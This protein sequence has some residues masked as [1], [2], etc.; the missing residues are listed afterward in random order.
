MKHSTPIFDRDTWWHVQVGGRGTGNLLCFKTKQQAIEER[1][2]YIDLY[3]DVVK[4]TKVSRYSDRI[5]TKGV[6]MV[7]QGIRRK[8]EGT[9]L[10]KRFSTSMLRHY[11]EDALGDR[12][13]G[14]RFIQFLERITND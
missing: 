13:Y 3:G 2:F 11:S 4:T 6:G 9:G 12:V 1:Q 8:T 5:H 7:R 10:Q 14:D